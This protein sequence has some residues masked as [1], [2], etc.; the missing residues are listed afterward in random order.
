MVSVFD[1]GSRDGEGLFET[2]RVYRG[3]PLLWE[4]HLERLVVSAAELGFPVP[5]SGSLLREGIAAVL[6]SAALMDAV[7]RITV[8]RGIAGGRPT[9][10]GCW[11]DAEP[12]DARL[13]RGTRRGEAT[14]VLSRRPFA[15]GSLGGFKTTS[16]LAYHLA[17]EE[18]RAAGAD[19]A[20]LVTSRG[21]VLEGA[22]SNV[23][24]VIDGQ[25]A[26]PPLES[27]ILPGITR[28]FVLRAC[29][30]LGIPMRTR[31]ITRE[32][33][34]G[35]QEVFVT[36]AVQGIVP[37]VSI[38]SRPIGDRHVANRLREAYGREIAA[39]AGGRGAP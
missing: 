11:I 15:P 31:P 13:W 25:P 14:V 7:V 27:G 1:R 10:A 8:T 6:E 34:L 17:R 29:R 26:T 2:L 38:E 23:F 37:A 3:L 19:E 20:L 18:C 16:R 30:E 22:A 36:N 5:P 32:E 39:L 21:E 12:V 4:R 9:R 24:A 28:G 33:L 35:A